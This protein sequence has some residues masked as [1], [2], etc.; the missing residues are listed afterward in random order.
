MSKTMQDQLRDIM[1]NVE[2]QPRPNL[3]AV[4]EV[5]TEKMVAD[6]AGTLGVEPPKPKEEPEPDGEQ[7]PK[8]LETTN[9]E[10]PEPEKAEESG[11]ADEFVTV[12]NL[13]EQLG[14]DPEA[15]YSLRI[16]FGDGQEPIALGELK[17][18]YQDAHKVRSER[19][20][21]ESE[22]AA[23]QSE[24]D[25]LR[26]QVQEQAN[27]VMPE[28]LIQAQARMQMIQ[29]Q[30]DG[31]DWPTLERTNP[32]EAAL[33]RQKLQ[34]A[35]QVAQANAVQVQ[36]RLDAT[37]ADI[38]A[39]R[40]AAQR[41]Q[42]DHARK[43]LKRLIPEWAEES[44]FKG[45]KE[46]MVAWLVT[47]GVPEQ[48]AR[49]VGSPLWIKLIRDHW[50]LSQAVTTAKPVGKAPRTLKPQAVR[51]SS[52]AKDVAYQRM[53]KEAASSRDVRVK[54]KAVSQLINRALSG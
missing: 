53:L 44:V 20:T 2:K 36:Q 54:N 8:E 10:A 47:Q 23:R 43:E 30:W 19:E 34:E 45:E 42:M 6:M 16:P 9:E 11:D 26:L 18:A 24:L 27:A 13:A 35:Y 17:D 51:D 52:R 4:P 12:A 46:Q 28:E 40:E 1:G 49:A 48:E 39:Q 32:G 31:M 5:D 38:E 14:V 41:E 29:A 25:N 37:R 7:P 3:E 33:Q 50:K 15:I 22:L 21:I